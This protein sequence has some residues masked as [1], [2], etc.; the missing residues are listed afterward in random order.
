MHL[1]RAVGL[2]FQ[3][4]SCLVGRRVCDFSLLSSP[5]AQDSDDSL[6]SVQTQC[7]THSL[8]E[9]VLLC[10]CQSNTTWAL[11]NLNEWFL[12]VGFFFSM[13]P[14]HQ[15]LGSCILGEH[16][17]DSSDLNVLPLCCHANHT[18]CYPMKN[19]ILYHLQNGH[20]KNEISLGVQ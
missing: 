20:V 14:G 3:I 7:C 19:V 5:Q 8:K 17:S 10:G 15:C 18:S 9:A 12:I 6:A 1:G 11:I 4:R 2:I 13:P 16:F